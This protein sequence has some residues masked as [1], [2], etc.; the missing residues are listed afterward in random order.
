VRIGAIVLA[1]SIPSCAMPQQ[2]SAEASEAAPDPGLAAKP[3]FVAGRLADDDRFAA[4]PRDVDGANAPAEGRQM[5]YRAS[6]GIEVARVEE[7][8]ERFLATVRGFGGHLSQ[9]VDGTVTVRVPAT[10]FEQTLAAARSHGRVLQQNLQASDVTKEYLD[11]ELRIANTRKARERLLALMEKA[12]KVEDL[13]KI[14][15][16]LRRLTTELEQMEGELK[17]LA[18]Q[19]ALSTVEVGFQ[20]VAASSSPR[21]RVANRF[22]WINQVGLEPMRRDF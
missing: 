2:W 10:H 5:I 16:Q 13:L 11:L 17:W 22:E 21:R 8:I 7:A 20:A 4:E 19:V 12:D 1:L 18:D 15:E 9:R 3:G 14:E 6:L